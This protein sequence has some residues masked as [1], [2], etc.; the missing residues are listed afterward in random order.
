M[1]QEPLQTPCARPNGWEIYLL[2]KR[3]SIDNE[4]SNT[5]EKRG[6]VMGVRSR[7]ISHKSPPAAT[8]IGVDKLVEPQLLLE[9]EAVVAIN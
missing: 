9:I 3:L 6:A 7:Y 8:M 2:I 1:R 5:Q 4:L